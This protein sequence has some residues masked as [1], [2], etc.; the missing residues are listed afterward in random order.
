MKYIETECKSMLVKSRLPDTDYVVNPYTGCEFGCSYCYASFM[1]RFVGQGIESWGQYVFVKANGVDVFGRE[2]QRLSQEARQKTILLSSV[3]DAWQGA[4]RKYRISRGVV[5]HL[6]QAA[7]PGTVSILTKSPVILDDAAMIARLPKVEVGVTVTS[8]DD[9]LS[10]LLEVRAPS[11]TRRI[12]TLEQLN[13]HGIKTYAF[14]GPLL[15]HFRYLPD[16]LDELFARIADTGTREVYVELVNASRYIR[17]RLDSAF[18]RGD[19][20]LRSAYAEVDEQV[21]RAAL[22]EIVTDIVQRRGLILRLGRVI[23][24]RSE[25]RMARTIPIVPA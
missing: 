23:D 5:G 16:K 3:T 13:R 1:G 18:G 21:H 20:L 2:L 9:T 11:A 24:H 8:T 4:E 22:A 6:V 15:P 10:R 12:H 17:T 7:Y 14:V 19:Q 25:T